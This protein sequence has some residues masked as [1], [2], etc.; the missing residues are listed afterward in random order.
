M[1]TMT[2]PLYSQLKRKYKEVYTLKPNDLHSNRGTHVFKRLAPLLKED[3]FTFIIPVSIV[4][5]L[6]A[7]FLLRPLITRVVSI[8]QYGF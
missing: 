4:L 6:I 8:L 2:D 3:P 5:T 7:Y 1:P